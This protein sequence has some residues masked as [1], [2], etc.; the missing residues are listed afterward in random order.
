ML[1]HNAWSR[2]NNRVTCT[3]SSL[4]RLTMLRGLCF[5]MENSKDKQHCSETP[6]AWGAQV[7]SLCVCGRCAHLAVLRGE[8][9]AG[10]EANKT[11]VDEKHIC[12]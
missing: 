7:K 11:W 1:S 9:T 6:E 8:Y 5:K 3:V 12:I 10:L 4:G 2:H